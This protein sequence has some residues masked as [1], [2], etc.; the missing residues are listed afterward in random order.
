VVLQFAEQ[1]KE[2]KIEIEVQRAG[3]PELV[4]DR[5]L[6]QLIT[7]NLLGNAIK[8]TQQGS[9]RV[10]AALMD[11]GGF[12]ISI[13]DDGPGIAQDQLEKIFQ[14]YVR[15]ASHGQAGMGLGLTIAHEAAVLLKARIWAQS[16]LGQGSQFHLDLPV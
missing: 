5:E 2:K 11:N 13:E 16:E 7:Q 3:W 8:Y 6:V 9:V 15:G 1:A 14:P 10:K 4:T 12:R